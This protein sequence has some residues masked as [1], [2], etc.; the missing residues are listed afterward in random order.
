MPKTLFTIFLT[1]NL[2]NAFGQIVEFELPT[3]I[4]TTV[5]VDG[6][7]VFNNENLDEKICELKR[8]DSVLI[9]KWRAWSVY[10]ESKKDNKVKGYSGYSG[11]SY[12]GK[13]DS[14]QKL[15][16]LRSSELENKEVEI[17]RKEIEK[18]NRA[19]HTKLILQL[20]RKFGKEISLRIQKHMYWIGMTKEMAEYSLGKPI[21]INRTVTASNV[22][23]QWVYEGVY[24]YFKNNVVESFQD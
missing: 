6:W 7:S 2:W 5:S 22:R 12:S 9:T 20:D 21:D 4:I 15:I 17:A 18:K 10:V 3:P 8:G 16:K 14:I 19:A 13:Y 1:V 11:F 24:L 23:E